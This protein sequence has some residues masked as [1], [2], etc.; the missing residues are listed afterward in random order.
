MAD[1]SNESYVDFFYG[2]LKTTTPSEEEQALGYVS[3]DVPD[4]PPEDPETHIQPR[5]PISAYASQFN[6]YR[7]SSGKRYQE[8]LIPTLTDKTADVPGADGMYFFSTYYKQ[9]PFTIN[10]AFDKVNDADMRDMRTWLNGKDIRSLIFDE[11][12]LVAYKA[13]VTGTPNFKFLSFDVLSGKDSHN[14][15]VDTHSPTRIAGLVHKGEGTVNLTCFYPYGESL[16]LF[17]E[18]HIVGGEVATTFKI[19]KQGGVAANETWTVQGTTDL[20]P[21]ATFSD[22]YKITFLSAESGTIEWDSSTGLVSK[23]ENGVVIPLNFSGVSYGTIN[24]GTRIQIVP[25]N[26]GLT[27]TFRQRYY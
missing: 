25:D 1:H 2:K 27:F 7:V 18:K 16:I 10:L 19:V 15:H 9:I 24:P 5:N 26:I 11:F 20:S 13:K 6:L 14:V 3:I 21:S 12:P 8:N 17:N 4:I 22:L 23:K